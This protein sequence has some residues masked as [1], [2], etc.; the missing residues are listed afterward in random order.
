MGE[1]TDMLSSDE[2]LHEELGIIPRFCHD[3]FEKVSEVHSQN[4][5]KVSNRRIMPPYESH[6]VEKNIHD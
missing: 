3:L 1:N 6:D 2:T 5:N 4:D